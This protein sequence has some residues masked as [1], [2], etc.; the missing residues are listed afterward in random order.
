MGASRECGFGVSVSVSLFLL[1]SSRC[2][3]RQS[4]IL[5]IPAWRQTRKTESGASLRGADGAG[6]VWVDRA[7]SYSL[8][9]LLGRP[10]Y[11]YRPVRC[12][13]DQI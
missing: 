7:W 1:W 3:E 5:A 11:A 10:V 6:L 4:L 13:E 12:S 8:F 2:F 9:D